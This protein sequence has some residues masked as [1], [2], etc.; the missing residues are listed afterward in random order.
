MV[1]AK[2]AIRHDVDFKRPRDTDRPG[3][4]RDARLGATRR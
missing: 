4:T 2:L 1:E 3:G